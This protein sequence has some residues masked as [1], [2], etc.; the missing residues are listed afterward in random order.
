[1]RV[2]LFSE[3]KVESGEPKVVSGVRRSA[4][5]A[6]RDLAMRIRGSSAE[7]GSAERHR[8]SRFGVSYG[9]FPIA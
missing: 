9:E 5:E 3:A 1:M 4:E 7:E 6:R 2:L 8:I